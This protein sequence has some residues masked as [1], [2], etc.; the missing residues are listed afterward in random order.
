MHYNIPTYLLTQAYVINEEESDVLGS[1]DRSFQFLAGELLS[2]VD[3]DESRSFNGYRTVEVL[4][5]IN[6]LSVHEANKPRI[7]RSGVLASYARL[8]GPGQAANEQ[9]LVAE[10]LWSLAMDCP[11]DVAKQDGCVQSMQ[12]QILF[13]IRESNSPRTEVHCIMSR[14][15]SQSVS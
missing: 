5:A 12:I 2:A 11:Q 3:S 7:I 13:R 6:K 1:D 15:V 9:V 8:L 14:S 4:T 10:G